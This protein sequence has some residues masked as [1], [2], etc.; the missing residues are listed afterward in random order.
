MAG[1]VI[2]STANLPEGTCPPW[3]ITQWPIWVSNLSGQLA[4][5]L[6]TINFGNT[7]PAPAD[8]D[9]PWLKTDANGY[10]DGQYWVY[11]GGFW[12]KKHPLPPGVIM[13][14]EGDPTTIDTFDGGEAAALTLTTGPMWEIVTALAARFPV[15]AGT[16]PSGTILTVGADGGEERH[17]LTVAELP[18]HAHAVLARSVECEDGTGAVRLAPAVADPD[19]SYSDTGE[20]GDGDAHNTV[21]PYHVVTFI[22]RSTREHYR[23]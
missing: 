5:T 2:I 16:F 13:L 23:A 21:P 8:Q 22:R 15:G 1:N 7:T 11:K 4:G 17:E 19:L 20:T 14:W 12:L 10:P 6:N 9:K 3:V 18:E